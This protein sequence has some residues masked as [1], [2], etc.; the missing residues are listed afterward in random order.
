MDNFYV[1]PPKFETDPKTKK[2]KI[3][4]MS[5]SK[6][7]SQS[8]DVEMKEYALAPRKILNP[9]KIE[10]N[11]DK[12][13]KILTDVSLNCIICLDFVKTPYLFSYCNHHGCYECV[14]QQKK[15]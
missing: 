2:L 7:F 9:D 8:G 12:I 6:W 4:G 14:M 10:I 1:A 3:N 11:R 15:R 5:T 13:F